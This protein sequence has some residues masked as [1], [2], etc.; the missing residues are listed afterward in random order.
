M[1]D[2]VFGEG[3]FDP[4][5]INTRDA[6]QKFFE[7]IEA[8]GVPATMLHGANWSIGGHYLTLSYA[9]QGP[10]TSDG[11]GFIDKIKAGTA[12]VKTARSSKDIW[13]LLIYL[14]NITTTRQTHW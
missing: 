10:A 6:L 1:V 3:N 11:T 7:K 8:A 2:E 4:A 13:I 9:V 5:T 14:Q 12:K